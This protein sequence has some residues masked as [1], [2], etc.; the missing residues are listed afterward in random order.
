MFEVKEGFLPKLGDTEFM[1]K[2]TKYKISQITNFDLTQK[3]MMKDDIKGSFDVHNT[4]LNNPKL[5]LYI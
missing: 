3:D 2:D 4:E 1:I 5:N